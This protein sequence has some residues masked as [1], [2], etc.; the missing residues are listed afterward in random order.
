MTEDL[1]I[2]T[3]A[4][5]TDVVSTGS[6]QFGAIDLFRSTQRLH[7]K[8]NV[9]TLSLLPVSPE[10][11]VVVRAPATPSPGRS[12]HRTIPSMFVMHADDSDEDVAIVLNRFIAHTNKQCLDFSHELTRAFNRLDV[13]IENIE[14]NN[15]VSRQQLR[16]HLFHRCNLSGAAVERVEAQMDIMVRTV[17]A[18]KEVFPKDLEPT[19]DERN[20]NM[21][22]LHDKIKDIEQRLSTQL[23]PFP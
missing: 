5:R 23:G 12:Q 18:I 21:N 10:S 9:G 15:D 17:N 4:L 16:D 14:H 6:V 20:K 22:A 1:A 8:R 11:S 13:G 2:S 19:N 7:A 3:Q